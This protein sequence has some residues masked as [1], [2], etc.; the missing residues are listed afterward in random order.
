MDDGQRTRFGMCLPS[1]SG[2]FVSAVFV[3]AVFVSACLC[4]CL[5]S[6]CLLAHGL[7]F[8]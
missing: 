4:Q 5:G 3:S 6:S 7:F 1:Y 8:P 2:M